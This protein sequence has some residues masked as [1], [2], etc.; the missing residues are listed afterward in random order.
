MA[1]TQRLT[2]LR[3]ENQLADNGRNP[4]LLYEH[5]WE[6]ATANRDYIFIPHQPAR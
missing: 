4:N 3:S 2:S 5:E 6:Q 1:V